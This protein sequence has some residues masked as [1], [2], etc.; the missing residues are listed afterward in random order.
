MGPP[1][2]NRKKKRLVWIGSKTFKF[3]N[4]IKANLSI[5][6]SIISNTFRPCFSC[7]IGSNPVLS[8]NKWAIFLRILIID[9][10]RYSPWNLIMSI[11]NVSWVEYF[12]HT[13]GDITFVFKILWK[14]NNIGIHITKLTTKI[15]YTRLCRH[16]SGQNARPRR[17]TNRPLAIGMLKSNAFL[18][19]P[20]DIGR[21]NC[22][23]P[24]TI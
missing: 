5:N 20:V 12:T 16:L 7:R 19:Q 11:V 2:A 18:G 10:I 24:V 6:I 8:L 4:C 22:L 23:V 14:R 17:A 1:E 15:P 21:T 3:W 13:R 9:I